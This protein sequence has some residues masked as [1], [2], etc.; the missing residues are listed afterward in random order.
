MHTINERRKGF[1]IQGLVQDLRTS[2]YKIWKTER[3]LINDFV[4]LENIIEVTDIL[5]SIT[6]ENIKFYRFLKSLTN[7]N[8]LEIP[9]K[10]VQ[11]VYIQMLQSIDSKIEEFKSQKG[12]EAIEVEEEWN[13]LRYWS[14]LA[15][16]NYQEVELK[17][18]VFHKISN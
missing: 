8:A 4:E 12:V 5:D 18:F 6:M 17:G 14:K 3:S 15:N 9:S 16:Y 1:M 7:P 2:K 11:A 13:L 10:A